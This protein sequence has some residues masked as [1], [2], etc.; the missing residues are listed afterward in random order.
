MGFNGTQYSSIGYYKKGKIVVNQKEKKIDFVV[1]SSYNRTIEINVSWSFQLLY[2][3]LY[4]KLKKLAYIK[5][6]RK[7]INGKEYFYYHSIK[8]Y[9]L[10]ILVLFY[11]LLKVVRLKLGFL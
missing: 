8:F 6:D 11:H 3:R 5:A 1:I 9:K 7:F 10:K 4:L 2:E